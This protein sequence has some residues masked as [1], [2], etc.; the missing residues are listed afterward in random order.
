MKSKIREDSMPPIRTIVHPTDSSRHSNHAFRLACSL[1]R[2]L[3]ARVVV[4]H[5]VESPAVPSVDE[6]YIVR[7]DEDPF[8]WCEKL[9]ESEYATISVE[10]RIEQGFAAEEILRVARETPCDLIVLGTHGRTGFARLVMGSVAEAVLRNAP[11]PVVTVKVP[12]P[13][14]ARVTRHRRRERVSVAS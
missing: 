11:C 2:D 6:E 4:M 8:D 14:V 9:L 3:D 10:Y 5:V 1:A 12:M 7:P 13:T